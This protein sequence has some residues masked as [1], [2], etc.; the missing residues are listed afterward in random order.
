MLSAIDLSHDAEPLELLLEFHTRLRSNLRMARVMVDL[1]DPRVIRSMAHGLRKFL[2]D[3]LPLHMD[4]EEQSVEPRLHARNAALDH[5]LALMDAEH[6]NDMDYVDQ[7][8]GIC[9]Q[10][11]HDPYSIP[12]LR[13]SLHTT[14]WQLTG[15]LEAHMIAEETKIFP[16]LQ[17]LPIQER[18]AITHEMRRR[19]MI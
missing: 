8:L 16:A 5:A 2:E 7:M 17:E 13:S 19:R 10:L 11:E 15:R 6:T 4:D 1:T 9:R 18:R 3:E 12:K 14:A